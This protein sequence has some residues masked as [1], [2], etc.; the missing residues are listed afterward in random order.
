MCELSERG[1]RILMKPDARGRGHLGQDIV[2]FEQ[3][4]V[5]RRFGRFVCVRK[6]GAVAAF[7]VVFIAGFELQQ[8]NGRHDQKIAEVRVA[9][10]AKMRVRKAEYGLVVILV[11]GA[12]FVGVRVILAA[13]VVRLLVG[14]R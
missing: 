13:D 8:A 7:R 10:A 14:I 9:G 2:V 3:H 5:I 12:V 11:T 6:R 1:K 4:L